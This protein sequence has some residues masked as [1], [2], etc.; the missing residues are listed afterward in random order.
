VALRASAAGRH[1]RMVL[2]V[3]QAVERGV[4]LR[5]VHAP[6]NISLLEARPARPIRRQL[7]EVSLLITVAAG[8]SA[9][10]VH[11]VACSTFPQDELVQAVRS[12]R[13]FGHR[14]GGIR[15]G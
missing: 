13:H 14:G 11:C 5:A 12:R 10:S 8:L 15:G 4:V 3:R 9:M 2:T 1:G 6:G 7:D